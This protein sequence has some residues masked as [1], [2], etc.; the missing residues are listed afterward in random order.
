MITR[1]R[2]GDKR[3][4]DRWQLLLRWLRESWKKIQVWIKKRTNLDVDDIVELLDLI[5]NTTYF[6]FQDIFYKQ[7]T[8]SA[9]GSPVSPVVAEFC[10]EQLEGIAIA[11]APLDCR[12]S[13]WKRYVDDIREKV[14]YFN[15]AFK[16][17]WRHE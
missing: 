17:G 2:Y 4:V 10:M 3:I 12:P 1:C 6:T 9:M 16:Y 8:G 11:T 7:V 15:C 14:G 13:L 5:L